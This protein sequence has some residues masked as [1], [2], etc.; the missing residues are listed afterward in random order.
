MEQMEKDLKQAKDDLRNGANKRTYNEWI[1]DIEKKSSG[2]RTKALK[3]LLDWHKDQ[4]MDKLQ[5]AN[6]A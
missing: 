2:N 1:E 6:S 5:A 4:Q 3:Q